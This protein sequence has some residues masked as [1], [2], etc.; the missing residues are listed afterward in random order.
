MEFNLENFMIDG[1]PYKMY[2]PL[3]SEDSFPFKGGVVKIDGNDSHVAFDEVGNTTTWIKDSARIKYERVGNVHR[4]IFINKYYEAQKF[5][6]YEW[7]DGATSWTK[8]NE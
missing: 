7:T 4:I 3:P 2:F 1:K 5:A 6:T 8:V